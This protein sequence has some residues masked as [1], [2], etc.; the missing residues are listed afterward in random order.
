VRLADIYQRY[1]D[2]TARASESVRT[3]A[4]AGLAASWLFGGGDRID[5]EHL[6]ISRPLLLAGALF[7]ST[8]V[9]DLAHSVVGGVLYRWYARRME[10]T[11]DPDDTVEVPAWL[12]RVPTSFYY[13]KIVLLAAGYVLLL[14]VLWS[15]L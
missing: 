12:P 6:N 8:L 7:A 5:L 10:T 4:L 11:V 2:D 1:Y 13:A 14:Q 15:H 9:V 3:L